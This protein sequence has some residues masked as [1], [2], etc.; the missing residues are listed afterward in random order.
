MLGVIRL[1]QLIAGSPAIENLGPASSEEK[2]SASLKTF[3]TSL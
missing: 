1:V 2:V 3:T